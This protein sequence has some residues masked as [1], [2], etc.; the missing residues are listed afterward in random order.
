[1][2]EVDNDLS[3]THHADIEPPFT[4]ILQQYKPGLGV[5]YP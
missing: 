4:R 1:M 2:G 5:N 3:F